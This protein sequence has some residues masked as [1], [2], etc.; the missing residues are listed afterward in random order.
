[1]KRFVLMI[2]TIAILLFPSAHAVVGDQNFTRQDGIFAQMNEYPLGGCAVGDAMYLFGSRHIYIWRVGDEAP[3]AVE[4]ELP[5]ADA[6]ET[7]EM[8]CLFGDGNGLRALLVVYRL[9]GDSYGPARLEIVEVNLDGGV[10]FGEPLEADASALAVSYGGSSMELAQINNSVYAGGYLYLD[11]FTDA[12][13]R[14]VYA[15]QTDSGAGTYLDIED[16]AEICDLAD[17]MVMIETWDSGSGSGALWSYGPEGRFSEVSRLD[18]RLSEIAYSAES[19]RLFFLRDGY[20]MAATDFDIA[21]AEP[22]AEIVTRDGDDAMALLLPGDY[23][24]YCSMYD[25][26]S[27]RSTAPGALPARQLVVQC[28]GIFQPMLDA[29]YDFTAA[30]DDAALILREDWNEGGAIIEAMMSRDSS[31]DIYVMSMDT[32]AFDALYSRGYMVP[33]E[34]PELADAV[35]RM[36][37]AIRDALTRDGAP[38]AVPVYASGWT[39]GLDAEGFAR[40]GVEELPDN[41]PDFLKLMSELPELLPED[42]SVRAFFENIYTAP[43]IR[44]ALLNQALESWHMCLR[45]EGREISY[46]D[47]GLAEVIDGIMELDLEALGLPEGNDDSEEVMISIAGYADNHTLIQM[48]VNCALGDSSSARPALLSIA[49]GGPKQLPLGLTVAFINPFSANPE[50]ASEYLA[51]L[52]ARLSASVLY[53]LSGEQSE[54]VRGRHYQQSMENAQAE[55]ENARAAYAEAD[56]VDKPMWEERI[57]MWEEQIAFFDEYGWDIS[58][59]DIEWYRAHADSLVVKGYNYVNV[60]EGSN[61]FSD[62]TEQLLSGRMAAADFLRELDRRVSMK[63]REG[64]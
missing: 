31:S 19:A 38:I 52:Y 25:S 28:A 18:A 21:G 56:D 45:A 39:M 63:S 48:D 7:R 8:K 57:A 15:L 43:Q 33:I 53:N 2:L 54:P 29:Y 37:P 34:S 49:P 17:G 5:K 22:V 40:I 4:Y 51:T 41:W 36:Y 55:L 30:H 14:R 64:M 50:L 12:G 6:G 44:R 46:D 20:V 32:E 47:P 24:V 11:V 27:I 62:L 26:V 9:D 42:G 16:V 60:T 10:S 3:A 1:M 35:G 23:Y 13:E 58:P 61:E 59:R